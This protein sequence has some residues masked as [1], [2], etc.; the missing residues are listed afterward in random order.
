VQVRLIRKEEFGRT[1]HALAAIF[2]CANK[3]N[4]H[5]NWLY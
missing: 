1:S 4:D 3:V 5:V 2:I